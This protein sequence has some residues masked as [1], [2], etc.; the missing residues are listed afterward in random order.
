MQFVVA[1]RK[2]NPPAG[3]SRWWIVVLS[4]VLSACASNS[5]DFLALNYQR[6]ALVEGVERNPVIVI[7]GLLGTTLRDREADE[8]I[9]G[10]F[11]RVSVNPEREAGLRALALPFELGDRG[12]VSARDNVEPAWVLERARV[13]LLG[14]PFNLDVYAGILRT[15]GAGGYRDESLGTAGAIDYGDGHFTCFQFPYDWRRDIV[16]SAQRLHE[17]IEAKRAYVSAEY[18]RRFGIEDADVRFDLV[19]HSMGALVARYYLMYGDQDLPA[20]GSLPELTWA[21]ANAVDRVILVGAPNAGST[22]TVRN[23]VEGLA[24]GPLQPRYSPTL[25][26]TYPSTYQLLPRNGGG[27]VVWADNGEPVDNLYSPALW[28]QLGWGLADADADPELTLLLPTAKGSAER[29]LIARALQSRLLRRAERLHRALDRA[30]QLPDSL[31]VMLV[32][33]DNRPTAAEIRVDRDTGSIEISRVG[34]GDGTVLR[35]SVLNDQRTDDD[36]TPMLDSPL[37]YSFA[38]FLPE[39]HKDLTSHPTFTDN[40]LYW[41]LEHPRLERRKRPGR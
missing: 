2:E 38:L 25:L 5:R 10:G 8:Y 21:G 4:L 11:D 33:G 32:V 34:D 9:W 30:A 12:E 16:E 20:D 7:P 24:L 39:G 17:F 27:R 15:L 14:L 18:A 40:I 1:P 28:Q 13:R 37:D 19:A 26:G 22:Y 23:L 31:E 41:L 35:S 36:W 3:L 29:E 6:S